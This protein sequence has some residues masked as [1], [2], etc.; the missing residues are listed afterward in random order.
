MQLDGTGVLLT[1]NAMEAEITYPELHHYTG[2][3]GL[4]GMMQT[5]T[6]WAT[7]YQDLNDF[8]EVNHLRTVLHAEAIE[9]FRDYFAKER[10]KRPKLDTAIKNGGGINPVSVTES[11]NLISSIYQV[12][13]E[14]GGSLG[15]PFSTPYIFSFCGHVGETYENSNGLLSQWRSYARDEGYALV[16]DT[17]KLLSILRREFSCFDYSFLGL[18]DVI[19]DHDGRLKDELKPL[20]GELVGMASDYYSGKEVRAAPYND[21]VRTTA[22]VKHRS[23]SEEREVR[24]IAAPMTVELLRKLEEKEPGRVSYEKET[25]VIY[26]RQYKDKEISY[27]SLFD[28]VEIEELPISRII[29]GPHAN[30]AK[31]E[32]KVRELMG[33]QI[34]IQKSETPLR[35]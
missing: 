19:Y 16:F 35:W 5:K 27:I 17:A 26:K 23:F 10:K 4:S 7:H 33:H 13:Y 31:L 30:Q 8:T 22:R 18:S 32:G 11:G 6:L 21:F 20:L 24:I 3:G 1:I 25:K 28:F 12:T 34:L 15:V 2:W 29:I 14:D 9:G